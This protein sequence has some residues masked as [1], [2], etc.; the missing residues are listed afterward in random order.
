M[1]FFHFNFT[2]LIHKII[3]FTKFLLLLIDDLWCRML[4]TSNFIQE[5]WHGRSKGEERSLRLIKLIS[6][7]WH[8]WEFLNPISLVLGQGKASVTGFLASVNRSYSLHWFIPIANLK[9]CWKINLA[10]DFLSHTL[11]QF[12]CLFLFQIIETGAYF[13]SNFISLLCRM[14]AAL[15]TSYKRTRGSHQRRSSCPL[16]GITGWNCNK[17]LAKFSVAFFVLHCL[18]AT[19]VLVWFLVLFFPF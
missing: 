3:L 19:A 4:G 15:L 8:G 11:Y 2:S 5:D 7:L 6:Y 9:T 13:D 14:L 17:W 18:L 16:V 10:L 1:F 12:R